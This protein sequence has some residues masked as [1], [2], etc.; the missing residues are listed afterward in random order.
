MVKS[1]I[2]VGMEVD[3]QLTANSNILNTLGMGTL[4]EVECIDKFGK[5]KWIEKVHNLVVN[6]GLNDVLNT[7]FKGITYTAEFYVGLILDES[8]TVL[9]A[10]DTAA[11]NGGTNGWTETAAYTEV[12]REV[13]TLGTVAAQSVSNTANKASFS[14]NA[15]ITIHGAFLIRDAGESAGAETKS[16]TNGSLFG[17]AAFSSPRAAASGDTLNVTVTLTAASV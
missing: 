15:T 10:G 4:Y 9:A 17:E 12:I 5:L 13:L 8:A 3:A 7:F 14:I 11:Q 6:E 2:D 1:N 16:G